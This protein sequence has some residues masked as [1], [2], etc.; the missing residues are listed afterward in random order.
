MKHNAP[1]STPRNVLEYQHIR[2]EGRGGLKCQG[3][4]VLAC[5]HATLHFV[6][7]G[8][9]NNGW[10]AHSARCIPTVIDQVDGHN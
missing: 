9:S 3:A 1:Q 6:V 5:A 2:A 4:F 7:V 8:G 10:T